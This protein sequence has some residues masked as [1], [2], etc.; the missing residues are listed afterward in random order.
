MSSSTIIVTLQHIKL[1]FSV[2]RT[3]ENQLATNI[4]LLHYQTVQVYHYQSA[5]YKADTKQRKFT[6][7]I[8][9]N[10]IRKLF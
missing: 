10:A 9:L 6:N 2:K 4:A 3:F 1:R 7:V 5:V 8:Q